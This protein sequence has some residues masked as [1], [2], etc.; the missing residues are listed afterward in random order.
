MPVGSLGRVYAQGAPPAPVAAFAFNEGTGTTATDLSGTGNGGTVVNA[1]WTTGGYHGG[2]LAFD[3]TSA[4]R[5]TVPDAASLHMSSGM[6]LE[7]W[8]NPSSPDNSDWR[9]IIY[10]GTDN[11]VLGNY[12]GTGLLVGGAAAGGDVTL[13]SEIALLP[14]N[15]WTHVATTYDGTTVRLYVNGTQVS[16]VPAA[17]LIL[18]STEP[19][20]IGGSLADGGRFAGLIDDVRLY[21]TALTPSQIQT[22]MQTPVAPAGDTQPPTSP[23]NLTATSLSGPVNVSWTFSTDNVSVTGYRV[24][25]CQGVSCTTF[26]PIATTTAASY[27][28][29]GLATGTTYRY[30]VRAVDPSGNLSGYSN[31][32]TATTMAATLVAAY[33]FN[34]GT[35]TTAADTSGTGNNGTVVNAAW[36]TGGYHGGALRFDGTSAARV[37]VPDA[38]SLHLS[39]GMTLEAWINPSSPVVSDWRAILYKGSDNYSY[40]VRSDI[41]ARHDTRPQV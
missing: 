38:P 15:T 5:V 3:G 1:T 35:G 32:A 30:R 8:V 33:G 4:A 37:T 31:V 23:T 10:K 25:R 36:T 16:S 34:D 11:Y 20:E 24:E 27:S 39:S 41:C 7:A 18:G 28:D 17:G 29:I 22:D 40:F 13:A 26:V 12:P 19:L 2:A 21:A 9:A 6:T 14:L